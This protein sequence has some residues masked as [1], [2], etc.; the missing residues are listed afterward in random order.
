MSIIELEIA[1]GL[2]YI[3]QIVYAEAYLAHPSYEKSGM[4]VLYSM[5]WT[6]QH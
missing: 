1:N 3:F 6:L 4:R 2:S 5:C